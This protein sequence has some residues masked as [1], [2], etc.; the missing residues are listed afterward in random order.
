VAAQEADPQSLLNL[1][2]RA[3]AQR[4]DLPGEGLEWVD[5]P[6]GVLH[7]RRGDVD[8]VVN[9]SGDPVALPDG[10]VLLA[11]GPLPDGL[12]PRDAAVWIR[13]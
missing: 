11:S 8:V 12:L 10:A 4:R 5:A 1:Y 6:A 13:R 3:I 2:R 7:L 9:V